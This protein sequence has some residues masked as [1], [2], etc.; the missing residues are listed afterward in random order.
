[1]GIRFP[2]H[3]IYYSPF[4]WQYKYEETILTSQ[5]FE[6]FESTKITP[7]SLPT[8][9]QSPRIFRNAIPLRLSLCRPRCYRLCRYGTSVGGFPV[10]LARQLANSLFYF[11]SAEP[12]GEA[13]ARDA[14]EY[15]E[16]HVRHTP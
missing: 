7:P 15:R 4:G 14:L 5:S 1:M 9:K 8:T 6:S 10:S 12:A 11:C 16:T 3:H 13:V 2:G